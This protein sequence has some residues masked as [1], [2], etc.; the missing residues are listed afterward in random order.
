MGPTDSSINIRKAL[1]MPSEQVESSRDT[2]TDSKWKRRCRDLE[3]AIAEKQ[4]QVEALTSPPFLC[5][6]V[7]RNTSD[8]CLVSVEGKMAQVQKPYFGNVAAG[9]SILIHMQS[10]QIINVCQGQIIGDIALVTRDK[11]SDIP[12]GMVEVDLSGGGP[13]LVYIQE[14][15]ADGPP[16]R[17]ARIGDRVG[18]DDANFVIVQNMGPDKSHEL[19]SL[20]EIEW[21]SIG[22]LHHAKQELI[23]AIVWPIKYPDLYAHYRKE[24]SKGILLWGPPG[25]GKTLL[26]K[27]A[28]TQIARVHEKEPVMSGFQHINGPEILSKWVGS[29]ERNIRMIFDAARKHFEMHQYPAIIFL[30]EVD[31]ILQKRG[32]GISSDVNKTIVPQFL[33][34]MD[35]IDKDAPCMVMMATN[36]PDILDGAAT[37]DGRLSRKIKIGRP[38]E[39]GVEHIFNIHLTGRPAANGKSKEEMA[40]LATEEM[41]HAKRGIVK[42]MFD[43]GSQHLVQL[44]DLVT[45]AM[46]ARVVDE[47]VSTALYRNIGD[48]EAG[49][50]PQLGLRESD[51]KEAIQNV[52]D[53]HKETGADDQLRELADA[54][55]TK[56]KSFEVVQN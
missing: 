16:V 22:G 3:E 47:A 37:R 1:K 30:D 8:G 19:R 56:I 53:E 4:E 20:P 39:E 32:M 41:F 12:E 14:S 11:G 33:G 5:A 6:T 18:L 28:A 26:G 2:D 46:V 52:V 34:E 48:R 45:G 55:N 15:P 21:D 25:C 31:S 38:D 50:E 43:D 49:R 23:E 10:K 17:V 40:R 7:V 51:L 36:R 24:W 29:A 9:Q 35:G 42:A 13:T 27:A 44:R 54:R